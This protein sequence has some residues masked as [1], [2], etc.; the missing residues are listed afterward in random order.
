MRRTEK[1]Y[2]PYI[3]KESQ[4][5]HSVRDCRYAGIRGKSGAENL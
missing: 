4:K 2:M 3:Q 5:L 1:F